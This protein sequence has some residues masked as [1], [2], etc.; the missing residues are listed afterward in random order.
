LMFQCV[1]R[2][3]DT[4]FQLQSF[5]FCCTHNGVAS[6]SNCVIIHTAISLCVEHSYTKWGLLSIG[7]EL[8]IFFHTNF[9][10]TDLFEFLRHSV[11]YSYLSRK[12][13]V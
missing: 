12:L 1:C 11:F 7:N 8:K 2:N 6:P 10:Q 9:F 13:H 3:S 5:V 4:S